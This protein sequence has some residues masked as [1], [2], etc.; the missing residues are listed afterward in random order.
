MTKIHLLLFAAASFI[1]TSC[2]EIKST[3]IV[4]KDGTATIEESVLLGAQLAA[5]MQ[6]GGGQGDQLKGLVMDKA[7]AEERAKKLGEGVTVKSHE[8]VKSADG[9][10]GVKIVFAVADLA[11]LKY[12]PFEPEQEGKPASKSE[13][14]TFALSGSTLTITNPDA[15]K[16]KG[17]DIEKPKKSAEEFAQI[18]TQMSMMKP[19]FAGMHMAVELKGAGG[20]ASSNATHQSDGTISYLDIQFEKLME[21][22]DAFMEVMESGE[23]GMS[24]SEAATKFSEIEGLKIEGKKVVTVELK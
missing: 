8:E 20:I 6:A 18:K 24:M 2:L 12:V 13:A 1:L 10:S 16:K 9:T 4:S 14:M 15:D 21:N 7:K 23:G 22:T 17:G 3:L 5:M 11:K 19:M